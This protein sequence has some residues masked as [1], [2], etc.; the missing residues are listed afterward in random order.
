[1]ILPAGVDL[2]E[3]KWGDGPGVV[4]ICAVDFSL[5]VEVI[6]APV[7]FPRWPR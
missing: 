3:S 7:I 6:C 2:V 1:L 4:V 5:V